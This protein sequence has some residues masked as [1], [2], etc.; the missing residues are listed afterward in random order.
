MALYFSACEW[1]R[2]WCDSDEKTV[3]KKYHR[4]VGRKAHQPVC[5]YCS[6]QQHWERVLPLDCVPR[7][8]AFFLLQREQ[9]H[10]AVRKQHKCVWD[11]RDD[12]QLDSLDQALVF[13]GK[14]KFTE[15]FSKVPVNSSLLVKSTLCR[16]PFEREKASPIVVHVGSFSNTWRICRPRRPDAP[17]KSTVSV[18]CK[19]Q[20][21]QLMQTKQ[22][23]AQRD[24]FPPHPAGSL[25]YATSKSSSDS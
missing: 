15:Y 11:G 2:A 18:I 6:L 21:T 23:T 17:V 16:F 12:T 24:P 20:P 7:C 8:L 1:Q 5:I 3:S 13:R 14:A 25:H 19:Q 9:W 4:T 10:W 22:R